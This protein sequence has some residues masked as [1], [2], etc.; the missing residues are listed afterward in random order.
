MTQKALVMGIG[1]R[2]PKIDE[3]A[4][5]APTSSV[6]GDVTLEAG[7]SVWYGAVV[8]GTWSGSPS[9]PSPMF[10]TTARCMPIPVFP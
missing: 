8:R 6:I 4:F 2:E 9:G 1:G 7:A 5:V 3:A 10:R